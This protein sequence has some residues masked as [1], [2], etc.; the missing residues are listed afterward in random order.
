MN[1]TYKKII[2]AIGVLGVIALGAVLVLQNY[3]IRIDKK[4]ST[5]AATLTESEAR[6][7]AEA[8]CIKG[9]EALSAGSYNPNSKTWWFDANLN[10]TREGCNPACVVSDETKTAEINWR[11][12]G[13]I[14]PD[15]TNPGDSASPS[16]CGVANCHGLDIECGT[17][18]QMCTEMYQL[19]DKCR[20]YAKCGVVSGTCQQ[21]ESPEFTACKSCAQKCEN[22]FPNDPDKAFECESQCGK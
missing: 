11:C 17:P 6:I 18:V 5:P 4:S 14:P 13:L 19:G 8:S 10:A 12:T 21:I 15:Q 20:Q 2:I 7:I 16:Q 9:G 22:D 1:P 3:Q